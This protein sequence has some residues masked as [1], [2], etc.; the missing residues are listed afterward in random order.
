MQHLTS[1]F[2][3][4]GG[5]V[6]EE[7]QKDAGHFDPLCHS[8][9]SNYYSFWNKVLIMH[10]S[11]LFVFCVGVLSCICVDLDSVSVL[12]KTKLTAFHTRQ[13]TTKKRN[14]SL[15]VHWRWFVC[16]F[17]WNNQQYVW[18]V[19]VFIKWVTPKSPRLCDQRFVKYV[20]ICLNSRKT[21][22]DVYIKKKKR[23]TNVQMLKQSVLCLNSKHE[24]WRLLCDNASFLSSIIANILFL[25]ERC[26]MNEC[27]WGK[28]KKES[29]SLQIHFHP[30]VAFTSQL[31]I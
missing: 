26:D 18:A 6:S 28:K 23:T 25:W 31:S 22:C 15:Q 7:K 29:R 16:D 30:N 24:L 2:F 8:H 10:S 14:V 21:R 17:K 1:L 9:C 13:E 20:D 5:T 27:L 19:A 3:F 4:A 12:L 11:W